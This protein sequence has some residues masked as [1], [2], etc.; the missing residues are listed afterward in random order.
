MS[1]N[2]SLTTA[3]P[4]VNVIQSINYLLAT[5]G[6]GSS[7]ANVQ[8]GNTV[9]QANT[10]TGQVYTQAGT[11]VS[12]LYGY[13]DIKYAN[14]ATGGSGF[15]GN[16]TMANYYGVYNT[17]VPV[18]STNPVDY[19]WYQVAGGFGTTKGLYYQNIG[20]GSINF[21]IGT[22]APSIYY[23]PVVDN[24]PIALATLA[25]AIV[26]AN[27]IQDKAITNVQIASNTIIGQNIQAGTITA[28]LLAANII[29]VN[30]SIQSTNATFNSPTSAG[31]WL[32]ASNGSARF[33]GNISIGDSLS[34]G[35]NAVV[36]N[37]LTVGNNIV[38]GGNANIA[39]VITTGVINANVV[40]TQQLV[41]TAATQVISNAN[42][43]G[44][45]PINYVNGNATIGGVGYIWPNYT[46]GFAL[47]G[48]TTIQTTTN[49]SPTGSQI[50]VSYNAYINSTSNPQ[51]NLVELWKSG[52]SSYYKDTMNI[53]RTNMYPAPGIGNIDYFIAPGNNGTVFSGNVGTPFTLVPTN[54]T[55]NFYDAPQYGPSPTTTMWIFGQSGA[56]EQILNGTSI[57]FTG[58]LGGIVAQNGEGY[59]Y[60]LFN[61]YGVNQQT[62]TS[63]GTYSGPNW[64]P[65]II[66]GSSGTIAFWNGENSGYGSGSFAF[67]SSGVFAD[68]NDVGAD[69]SNSPYNLTAS[70]NVNYV[71]VG[72]AGTI[73]YNT[74]KYTTG[75]NINTTTGWSQATSPTINNLNAVQCN[76]T[77][78]G[79]YTPGTRGNLWVAV[80]NN[81][82]IVYSTSNSGPWTLA[83]SVPTTNALLGIG[84]ANGTW[85]AVGQAGTILTST[86][87]SNWTGP[88][89]NPAD[90]VTVPGIG[91]R[92]LYG[93]AG[94]LAQHYFVAAGQEIIITSNTT[95]PTTG[96]WNSNAYL[97]GSSLN[98]TLTRI[99]FQGSFSN[100]AN[101][102][103]PPA[104]QQITNAQV[105]SGLY[106]DTNYKQGDI[107]TYY[108]VLGNMS[109][110]VAVYTNGP[111]LTITEIKR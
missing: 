91:A 88:I 40:N 110:N 4:Q 78:S 33:G 29:F 107:I 62:I 100:V 15:S 56:Y 67:E 64:L 2:F 27:T 95:N 25:N 108:L 92:D 51:Y 43:L 75:G 103:L 63:S 26:V 16:S 28:N 11:L 54:T 96:G 8:L 38:I 14:S 77:Q 65:T 66:V 106:T 18:E 39:G 50:Q 70:T 74:R 36:G 104:S 55:L 3:S 80:G 82:T 34:I 1:T 7:N 41:L 23:T 102:S 72:T 60:P 84:Y 71:V 21:S 47:G 111:N 31:F 105:V 19:Q 94:G 59:A 57:Q 42:N 48:G 99:Q 81:G 44:L 61:M 98:S 12:Y 69:L 68:L 20:G 46:R 101:V 79:F 13:V 90:G 37:N 32:N 53:V 9:V 10:T 87:G 89:A 6:A 24:T 35:N 97:G 5:Q 76:Y 49:G 17:A 22:T 93:V 85:V 45:I 30:Q 109:G 83:N 58:N 73:L 86:D 52:S